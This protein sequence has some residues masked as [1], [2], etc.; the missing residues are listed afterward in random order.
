MFEKIGL[1][2]EAWQLSVLRCDAKRILVRADRRC[3]KSTTAAALAVSFAMGNPGAKVVMV[4][5][6]HEMMQVECIRRFN[7]LALIRGLT[8]SMGGSSVIQVISSQGRGYVPDLLVIDDADLVRYDMALAIR[9]MMG[10]RVAI[11][12]TATN[13]PFDAM[14]EASGTYT[15]FSTVSLGMGK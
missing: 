13:T 12:A 7:P 9:P 14:I 2:P 10:N 15:F 5:P 3:G 8:V 11:F 1:T 6:S 4:T